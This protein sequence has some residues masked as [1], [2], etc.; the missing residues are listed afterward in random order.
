MALLRSSY[1]FSV[2]ALVS[3]VVACSSAA[4]PSPADSGDETRAEDETSAVTAQATAPDASETRVDVTSVGDAGVG[5]TNTSSSNGEAASSGVDAET[6]ASVESSEGDDGSSDVDASVILEPDFEE[7]SIEQV[8]EQIPYLEGQSVDVD[9]SNVL[10]STEP[11]VV[12]LD[13][14]GD[15]GADAAV[16]EQ[17][18]SAF[19][20]AC[21]GSILVVTAP[22]LEF[23]VGPRVGGEPVG[24]GC[25]DSE[26]VAG[27]V[28]EDVTAVGKLRVRVTAP[29]A[30]RYDEVRD[31]T[32]G[33][34]RVNG[35]DIEAVA[36]LEVIERL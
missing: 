27:C 25:W 8:C 1:A 4:P 31:V 28:P 23:G 33:D 19:V 29:L 7:L 9:L 20:A 26:C 10:T 36:L 12:S 34:V 32:V 5:S 17:R 15:A 13:D 14:A 6:T 35:V 30:P 21:A 22:T 2:A 16:C 11:Y 3:G 18:F 24:F